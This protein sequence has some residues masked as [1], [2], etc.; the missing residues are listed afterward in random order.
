MKWV[1]EIYANKKAITAQ[2]VPV[3]I[4]TDAVED[5]SIKPL[6][7]IA[8][9]QF[10]HHHV[11]TMADVHLGMG[12]TIFSVIAVLKVNPVWLQI[13]N[14]LKIDTTCVTINE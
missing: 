8:N 11:A 10:I 12:A 1:G 3:R 5:R 6:T 14:T 13:I 7:N 9:W 4:W 2:R